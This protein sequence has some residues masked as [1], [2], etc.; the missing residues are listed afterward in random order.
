MIAKDTQRVYLYVHAPCGVAS[1][2][3][4]GIREQLTLAAEAR[5]FLL[6]NSFF[7]REKI[8]IFF[9]VKKTNPEG[10]LE[11]NTYRIAL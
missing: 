8:F 10:Q 2:Y 3:N 6:K 11:Q 7:V 1:H 9:H 4:Y 5:E